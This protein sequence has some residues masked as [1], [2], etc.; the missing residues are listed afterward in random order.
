MYF[1]VPKGTRRLSYYWD[2]GPHEVCGPQGHVIATVDT[3]GRFVTIPVAAGW[4]GKIWSFRK[5]ATGHLW[6]LNAPN[7]LAA[8]P[9]A[10]LAPQE[11]ASED[12]VDPSAKPRE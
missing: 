8:S 10:L 6:F 1:Y 11:L 2:G 4:E 5:L 9:E 3:R 7:Y 12:A